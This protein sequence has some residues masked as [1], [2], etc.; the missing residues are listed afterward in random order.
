MATITSLGVG[1]G[2]NLNS[3]V[4]QLTALERRPIAQMRS[5]AARL[6]TQVSSFGQIKSLFGSLQDAS[7]TLNRSTLWNGT[8]TTSADDKSVAASGSSGAVAGRYAVQVD[9]LARSQTLASTTVFASTS[10]RVGSGTLSLEIGGWSA[11]QSTF[12]PKEGG[13]ALQ[14]EVSDADT[15]TSL[16]DKINS[17]GAGVTASLV[18]D[19]TGV[20]LSLRASATGAENAFRVTT[21]GASGDLQGLG[22]DGV[23]STSNMALVQ[24]AADARAIVNGIAVVSASND[25]AGVVD[26]LTLRLRQATSAPVEVAVSVD[27]EAVS[28]AIRTFAEAYNALVNYISDQTKFDANSRTGGPLQGDS[29]ANNL[30]SQLRTVLTTPTGA[31]SSF[32]RLSDVGLRAQRDGT[33]QVDS[34]KLSSAVGRLD[35]LKKAFS[36]SDGTVS[37]NDGFTRRYAALASGVLAVD[38]NLATRTEGLRK[39]ITRNETE[40][41]KVRDR[42]DRFQARLVEQYTALDGKVAQLNSLNSYVTQQLAQLNRS[43]AR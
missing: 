37:A 29:A 6:Q 1:S 23:N 31:S 35:E 17:A 3:I 26:G 8:T 25:L 41:S 16:R 11:D 2:L 7:N 19:S 28:K 22:Y 40:Q 36:N 30:M 27:T 32:G 38:G 12:T 9:Q 4:E 10:A 21:S 15:V 5:D 14:I 39:L 24:S 18:T 20:R 34:A 13:T 42:A 43:N 33:L